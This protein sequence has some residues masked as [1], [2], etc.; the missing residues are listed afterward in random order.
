MADASDPPKRSSKVTNLDPALALKVLRFLATRPAENVAGIVFAVAPLS[1][2]DH[3]RVMLVALQGAR[4]V[5]VLTGTKFW[6]TDAR[7][8]WQKTRLFELTDA[9]RIAA[10]SDV[11][12]DLK[13]AKIPPR[14]SQN[15]TTP[16]AAILAFL[17]GRNDPAST[18]EIA[19]GI[20]EGGKPSLVLHAL[21]GLVGI[22]AV[23]SEIRFR[24]ET[25]ERCGRTMHRD[26]RYRAYSA[27]DGPTTTLR[28]AR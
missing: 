6:E 10:N 27:V 24:H 18:A 21:R 25:F 17:R 26:V 4:L 12:P 1:G 11:A 23:T 19:E 20:K 14:A 2:G 7:F 22:G 15:L 8:R 9:G 16:Q 5:K 13:P 3:V 28:K